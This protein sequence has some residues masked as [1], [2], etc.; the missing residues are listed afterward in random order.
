SEREMAWVIGDQGFTMTL[1]KQIPKL[2]ST[3][4]RSWLEPWLVRQ[5]YP[6]EAIRE[7][8]VHP[9]GPK[10]LDAVQDSLALP[11]SALADSRDILAHFGNMSSPTVLFILQQLRRRSESGV[12]VLLGFGP[13]LVAEA[14]LLGN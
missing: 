2:I 12:T 6:L 5:G 7:W 10:I 3:H 4:L 14:V 8:A 1:T 11:D 13:G 9:G